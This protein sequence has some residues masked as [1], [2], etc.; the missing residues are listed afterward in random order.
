MGDQSSRSSNIL[1]QC[2]VLTAYEQLRAVWFCLLTEGKF[3]YLQW[4]EVNSNF[5]LIFGFYVIKLG[6]VGLLDLSKLFR[7]DDNLGKKVI[8][9]I[10]RLSS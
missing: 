1:I 10:H 9:E 2:S 6:T 5:Q 8:W 4:W 3:I 7:E